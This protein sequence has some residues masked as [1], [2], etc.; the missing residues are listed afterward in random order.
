MDKINMID[1][2]LARITRKYRDIQI[3]KIRKER[4]EQTAETEEI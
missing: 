4:G 1:K 3:N 2:S